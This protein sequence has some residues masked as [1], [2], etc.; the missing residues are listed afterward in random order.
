MRE[1]QYGRTICAT[2][3]ASGRFDTRIAAHYTLLISRILDLNFGVMYYS[4][5]SK[6]LHI[7]IY[8]LA[9]QSHFLNKIPKF[10]FTMNVSFASISVQMYNRTNQMLRRLYKTAI[11]V[12]LQSHHVLS[13]PQHPTRLPDKPSVMK[14]VVK[15]TAIFREM[16]LRYFTET[17][18]TY[19]PINS[20]FPA[21]GVNKPVHVFVCHVHVYGYRQFTEPLN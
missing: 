14:G 18:K 3:S 19:E 4:H 15:V 20:S 11:E 5:I 9:F 16:C 8:N 12:R 10:N 17:L 6:P 1:M 13:P 21:N 7:S 2:S